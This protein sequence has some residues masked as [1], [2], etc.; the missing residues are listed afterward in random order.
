MTSI[1]SFT[2][3]TD[4]VDD[5]LAAHVNALQNAVDWIATGPQG[6]MFNGQIVTSVASNNLTVAIKTLAG[7]DPS[8][9]DPVI[10]RVGNTMRMLTAALS[11]TKNAGTN[12]CNAGAAET[13]GQ[14]IDYFVYVV[15]NTTPATDILDFGFSR[16][17][18]GR[19]Y[20][21][22]SSTTTNEKYLANSNAS[23]PNAA[24]EV[25]VIGRFN[26]NLSAAAGYNWSLPATSIVVNRPIHSTR[27]LVW[28]P[29][30]TSGGGTPTTVGKTATYSFEE[31]RIHLR[32]HML[33]TDKGTATGAMKLTT[34]FTLPDAVGYGQEVTVTGV[35][36]AVVSI[37]NLLYIT[38]YDATS[39]WTNT[40][41]W[42]FQYHSI[43]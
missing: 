5:H 32:G 25:E 11:I 4:G 9:S 20:S 7:T 39:P 36:A 38:K 6:M 37:S 10:F 16:I 31:Q 43:L 35:G 29:T 13:A 30:V 8:A 3:K 1:F 33:V 21:D 26:A 34:P 23:A 40:W 17:P 12:W 2:A 19:L 42:Y 15:W 28:V 18:F 41:D 24:N 27:A 22:F 14:E